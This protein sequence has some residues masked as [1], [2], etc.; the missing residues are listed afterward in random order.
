MN[1]RKT[2]SSS[3]FEVEFSTTSPQPSSTHIG[4]VVECDGEQKQ[5]PTEGEDPQPS[6]PSCRRASI[7][8]VRCRRCKARCD[9]DKTGAPCYTCA[10]AGVPCHF[11]EPRLR[12]T[13]RP[14]PSAIF[15]QE[16]KV[17]QSQR[18]AKKLMGL[19]R[20]L[21][22]RRAELVHEV[23]AASYLTEAV[24]LRI[25]E[26]YK[27]HFSAETPFIHFPDIEEVVVTRQVTRP[28]G[29]VNLILLG[30]LALTTRF[31]PDLI[32]YVSLAAND[33][34]PSMGDGFAQHPEAPYLASR[35]S[36]F[37]ADTLAIALGPLETALTRATLFRVQ[38]FLMLGLF[39]WCQ[40]DKGAAAST[41][42]AVAT[43][44]ALKLKLDVEIISMTG[45]WLSGPG[46]TN[47]QEMRQRTMLSC[48]IMGCFFSYGSE[49]PSA[50]CLPRL[51]VMSSWSER[52]P[53][54][55]QPIQAD[56]AT[57]VSRVSEIPHPSLLCYYAQ[58]VDIWETLTSYVSAGGRN[59]ETYPPWCKESRFSQIKGRLK[60]L[61]GSLP[62]EF[63]LSKATERTDC[64]G[65]LV[66]FH[67]LDSLCRIIL[68]REL[69]PFIAIRCPKP[70][71]P[72]A[73][74]TWAFTGIS[75]P[76][77]FWE[78]GARE[79]FT[80]G[81][82]IARLIEDS[83]ERAPLS[84]LVTFAVY[85]AGFV[86]IYAKHFP[87]M[88]AEHN[89]AG[90]KFREVDIAYKWLDRAASHAANAKA[91][92][93]QLVDADRYFTQV[94]LDFD[95][96]QRLI[97]DRSHGGLEL[98]CVNG[99]RPSGF[100][101]STQVAEVGLGPFA[102]IPSVGGRPFCSVRPHG[103]E[104]TEPRASRY[105]AHQARRN[106]RDYVLRMEGERFAV[107]L[108]DVRSFSGLTENQEE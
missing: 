85:Q 41:Y 82:G 58:L 29:E 20:S 15:E 75:M 49:R 17:R 63:S 97:Y 55:G 1:S 35:A 103:V 14:P 6:G 83:Q 92:T 47:D 78:E 39:E 69:V 31:H 40:G 80:S 91:Y 70:V 33:D 104:H 2:T 45:M 108:Q 96:E 98:D 95:A 44:L 71:G 56:F 10:K 102:R 65:A 34:A 105:F 89:P 76:D 100:Q 64:G 101:G 19:F 42:V 66:S 73:E 8:C 12:P 59:V 22:H 25:L 30:I 84:P 99:G 13:K 68:Y 11:P 77:S 54:L 79:L 4:P 21:E 7:A 38:A 36:S 93:T 81:R 32:R 52:V 3:T 24:W 90:A 94:C 72:L 86:G 43:Q 18:R 67:V 9:N 48:L 23:L 107:A 46:M 26:T 88:D 53:G 106:V 60:N 62:V 50:A 57:G 37:F 28:A 61:S 5:T 74:R 16:A 87:H 51:R 27:L